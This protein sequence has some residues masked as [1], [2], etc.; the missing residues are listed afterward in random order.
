MAIIKKQADKFV[1]KTDEEKRS[2]FSQQTAA[3]F[4][5]IELA[6]REVFKNVKSV[7]NRPQD[8]RVG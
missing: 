6:R 2:E 7:I 4:R 5:K 8:F 1:E 3:L